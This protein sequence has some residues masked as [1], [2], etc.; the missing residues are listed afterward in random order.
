MDK[1]KLCLLA[2]LLCVMT[3]CQD[4]DSFSTNVSNILSFSADTV[5]LDT[6]FSAVPT[7]TRTF[8]VHNE[9]GDGIRCTNIRLERG[10][11]SGFRVNVDG[12]YLGS[13]S[14]YQASEVEIRKG[15]SIRVFVELT[16]PVNGRN[17]PWLVEDNL[18]FLLESGVTQKVNLNAYSWD[19]IK[20]RNLHITNDTTLTGDRPIIVYGK[21][22][23]KEHATLTLAAGTTLYFHDGGGIDVY[24]RLCSQGEAG[25]EVILRGDRLDWMFDY[26]PYDLM[27][28]L[29]DGIHFYE[30]SYDN[31]MEFTDLHSSFNGIVCDSAD[32]EKQKL[33]LKNMTV[34]NCQGKGLS[35][36]NCK[37]TAENCQFTNTLYEC[38]DI[39][40]GD[41]TM[42]HCTLAQFYPFD[43]NRRPALNYY[44][45]TTMPLLRM[46]CI[47]SIVTGYPEDVVMGA[48]E[49]ENIPFNYRFISSILR[50]PAVE[51]AEHIIDVIFENVEDTASVQGDKHFKLVDINTQHYDFHLDSLSPA[52]NKG[53]KDYPVSDDRDGKARDDQ[54]DIGCFEESKP[55]T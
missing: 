39:L 44:S 23:V 41:V 36:V 13:E 22:T 4:D 9:S 20:Y 10:N 16:S 25:K 28:G 11:Q 27:S 47:N 43:S 34:H 38:V 49:N 42:N 12:V 32:V 45:T 6:V 35:T 3:G 37:V 55:E 33:T 1:V 19:A 51:D 8:W 54:P 7:T 15:D 46:D 50:T 31:V 14:G 40:G 18:L 2:L 26:L 52:I 5:K 17:K 53:S 30:T 48:T 29:W 21:L 24:G